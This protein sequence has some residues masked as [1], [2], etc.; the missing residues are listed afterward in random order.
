MDTFLLAEYHSL[1]QLPIR[2]RFP[3]HPSHLL[4][5]ISRIS[6]IELDYPLVTTQSPFLN[7]QRFISDSCICW[8]WAGHFILPYS[9]F[10]G[11]PNR[12][13]TKIYLISI[14]GERD[15]WMASHH[16]LT[17]PA[18]SGHVTL[19]FIIHLLKVV[20]WSLQIIRNPSVIIWLKTESW[21]HLVKSSKTTTHYYKAGCFEIAQYSNLKLR[22]ILINTLY[23][24]FYEH[25][26]KK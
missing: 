9:P 24:H 15:L 6:V 3:L 8:Y 1:Q 11:Q 26:F 21:K 2:N 5:L 14:S 19:L 25:Y 13:V 20:T 10:R 17:A 16:Q 23:H 12:K 4:L 7:Q 22:E 18:P